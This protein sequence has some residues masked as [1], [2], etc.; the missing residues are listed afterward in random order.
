M[1]TRPPARDDRLTYGAVES[2]NVN[3][4]HSVV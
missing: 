4:A 1:P 2:V 3:V